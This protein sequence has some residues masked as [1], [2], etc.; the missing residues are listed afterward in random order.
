MIKLPDGTMRI[1]VQGLQRVRVDKYV[2][3]EPYLAA[4]ISKRFDGTNEDE[5]WDWHRARYGLWS[6]PQSGNFLLGVLSKAENDTIR[7][8]LSQAINDHLV[9]V[10][11]EF[12]DALGIGAEVMKAVTRGGP[13][14]DFRCGIASRADTDHDIVAKS[15]D[16]TERDGLDAAFAA[17]CQRRT[18]IDDAPLALVHHRECSIVSRLCADTCGN[19][20]DVRIG[21]ALERVSGKSAVGNRIGFAGTQPRHCLEARRIVRVCSDV[22]DSRQLVG[23]VAKVTGVGEDDETDQH[24]DDGMAGAAVAVEPD[25]GE[26]DEREQDPVEHSHRRVTATEDRRAGQ[27]TFTPHRDLRCL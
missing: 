13:Q 5:L 22:V 20:L 6:T 26:R 21:F 12:A 18:F 27:T 19:G 16:R 4:E 7:A 25:H 15:H 24:G 17:S 23:L 2:Q 11:D 8:G 3:E 14:V 10:V 9:D 1:L